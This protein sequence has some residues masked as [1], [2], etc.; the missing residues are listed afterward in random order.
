MRRRALL[1]P[2]LIALTALAAG[3]A[4]AIDSS[5]GIPRGSGSECDTLRKG[6]F[7]GIGADSLRHPAHQDCILGLQAHAGAGVL[8]VPLDWKETEV[9]Q[10]QYAWG[11]FDNWMRAV[12]RH[13]MRVLPILFNT[14]PF[15]GPQT[16]TG[17]YPPRDMGA[18][19]RFARAAAQRYGSNGDFWR[20]NPG[21]PKV[22]ITDWQIWN[23]PSLSQYWRPRP[24]AKGYAKML[25]AVYPA[26]KGADRR[27]K[28]V[29]GGL[30]DSLQGGAI[31]LRPY[32]TQLYK[33]GAAKYFDVMGVNLYGTSA[34]AV[35]RN[36]ADVRLLM[37]AP[38]VPS[39]L[40]K[41]FKAKPKKRARTL[42]ALKR[43][44]PRKK[45]RKGADPRGGIWLTEI[46]WGTGGPRH[47]FNLGERGQ[48][49]QIGKLFNGLYKQRRKL[50]L[51]GIIYFDWQDQSPYPPEFKDQ[52]GL[53]TGLFDLQ[54][55]PKPGYDAYSRVAPR[56]K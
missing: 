53:H 1:A 18:F 16:P 8:R 55:N 11:N 40:R 23:E 47:R 37:S 31:R 54:G 36:M 41:L 48:A 19:A 17:S 21:V 22:P 35:I 42:R 14:P 20:E 28:I 38:K 29:T 45:R 24:K 27:A 49:K 10:G 2:L 32:I 56:L 51:R 7:V 50:K 46:G 9:A 15:Y 33:A 52:W 4:A 12:A 44:L 25:K 6:G 13:R 26:I 30:P 3:Q 5:G 43:K 39:L 34:K